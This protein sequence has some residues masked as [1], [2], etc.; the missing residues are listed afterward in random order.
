MEERLRRR[1]GL[2]LKQLL[3]T[4]DAKKRGEQLCGIERFIESRPVF[5]H[6]QAGDIEILASYD[7]FSIYCCIRRGGREIKPKDEVAVAEL[8][9]DL[10]Y[11]YHVR[12]VV[13]MPSEQ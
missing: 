1:L 7:M 6:V 12:I 2:G 11:F 8:L 9:K 13:E 10:R 5:M 4:T 3:S